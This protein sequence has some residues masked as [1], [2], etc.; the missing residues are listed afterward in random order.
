[1]HALVLVFRSLHAGVRCSV[2]AEVATQ[3]D[4]YS[5]VA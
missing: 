4:A 5:K 3:L 1:M 2:S